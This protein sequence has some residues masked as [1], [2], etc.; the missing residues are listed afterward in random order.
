MVAARAGGAMTCEMEEMGKIGSNYPGHSYLKRHFLFGLPGLLYDQRPEM[1]QNHLDNVA[2][3]LRQL[4][5]TG[6]DVNGQTFF[7]ALIGSTG[8]MKFQAKL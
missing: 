5:T 8:D 3:N 2:E 6:I 7:G 1:L 4:F